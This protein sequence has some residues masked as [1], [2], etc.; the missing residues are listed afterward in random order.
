MTPLEKALKASKSILK[1]EVK[2]SEKTKFNGF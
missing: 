1:E 2:E